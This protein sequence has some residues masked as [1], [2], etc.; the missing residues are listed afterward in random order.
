MSIS[1]IIYYAPLFVA[2]FMLMI[3]TLVSAYVLRFKLSRSGLGFDYMVFTIIIV[4]AL[5]IGGA[6]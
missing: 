3:F 6:I 1:D 5:K 4:L 2:P